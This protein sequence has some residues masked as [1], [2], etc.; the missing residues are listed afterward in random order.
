MDGSTC[1]RSP[2]TT[3]RRSPRLRGAARP[4]TASRG[5]WPR[6]CRRW[7]RVVVER[8]T[9]TPP[10]LWRDVPD[11]AELLRRLD[12][13]ARVRRAEGADLRRA[14]RQAARGHAAG[15][16]GGRGRVRRGGLDPVGGRRR[17]RRLAGR[18]PRVQAG[19]EGRAE[20]GAAARAAR[21]P[22]RRGRW[23]SGRRARRAGRRAS[24][25]RWHH[26]RVRCTGA[27]SGRPAGPRRHRRGAIVSQPQRRP[28]AG[29]ADPVL[30]TDAAAVVRGGAHGPQAPLRPDDGDA[31]ARA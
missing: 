28:S 15:L 22:D 6:G 11:G 19:G 24:S 27:G 13:A 14:A 26:E 21:E 4:S 18:G 25:V 10:G 5:R 9:A 1:G 3:P 7:P 29:S 12:C 2:R 17:R 23:R 31:A 20:G 16:A 30:I 8:T